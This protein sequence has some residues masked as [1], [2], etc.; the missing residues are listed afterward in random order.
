MS[1][2]FGIE[3]PAVPLCLVLIVVVS[4][5]YAQFLNSPLVFDD[6]NL[7]LDPATLDR[8]LQPAPLALRWLPYAS[9]A[10]THQL[11]G[12]DLAWLRAENFLLHAINSALVFLFLR[13]L[14]GLRAGAGSTEIHGRSTPAGWLAFFAALIFAVH[15][16]AVYAVAYLVQRTILMA[17]LFAL[18]MWITYLEGL[19]RNKHGL[20]LISAIFYFLAVFS[21]EHS[22]MAAAVA[23]LLA[24]LVRGSSGNLLKTIAPSFLL[25][26]AIAALAIFQ[27]R[28]V[29]GGRY[30]LHAN[31]LLPNTG[32]LYALLLNAINQSFLFFQ[33]LLLWI[34]PSPAWMSVDIRVAFPP[35]A[36]SFPQVLGPI[37][38][39]VFVAA[40]AVFLRHR[41]A[42]LGFALL[43][44]AVLFLTEFSVVRVQEPFVLYRSYLW[45]GGLLAALPVLVGNFDRSKVFLCLAAISVLL[46]PV[47]WNRLTT[48][49]HPL[50]LWDDAASLVENR[51]H[52]PGVDRIY[53]NRANAFMRVKLTEKALAD[54]NTAIELNP[55]FAAAYNNRG[56]LNYHGGRY[57]SALHDFNKAAELDP[58]R[59]TAYVGLGLT[60]VAL[61][62][63]SRGRVN[64]SRACDLGHHSACSRLRQMDEPSKEQAALPPTR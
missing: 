19:L 51:K 36:W 59:P 37:L 8:L 45:A 27:S 55:G 5:V 1:A 18:L 50:L 9:I 14:F 54:Y 57:N 56:S 2:V 28:G 7:F 48:F 53:Y 43:C 4:A 41:N 62:D 17:T 22:I 38:F 34:A 30:E 40:G 25:F 26:A 44:P 52:L 21:K 20:L 33:Y 32:G 46:V 13:R 31:E 29:I 6:L 23:F 10:W 11:L 49:T 60:Y 47:T 39:L 58:A 16:V 15:P 35:T 64:L 42:L 12:F 3:P 24:V 63:K 61:G